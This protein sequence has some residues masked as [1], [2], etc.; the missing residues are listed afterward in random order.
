[1]GLWER[2]LEMVVDVKLLLLPRIN[3]LL[4]THVDVCLY[5][6]LAT[7]MGYNLQNNIGHGGGVRPGCCCTIQFTI[8]HP[9]SFYGKGD[10]TMLPRAITI[11]TFSLPLP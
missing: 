4:P 2:Q 3:L 5:T 6:I 1:M 10:P 7:R 11:S 8:Q 9:T